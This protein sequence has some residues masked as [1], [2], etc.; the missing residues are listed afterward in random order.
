MNETI[1][2]DDINS[3][4]IYAPNGTM[5][6][7][8]AKTFEDISQGRQVSEEVFGLESK[9][10]IKDENGMAISPD[11]IMVINPFSDVKDN[12][13]GMLMANDKLRKDYIAIHKS[14]GNTKQVN[15]ING[16]K[17]VIRS[18]YG[19]SNSNKSSEWK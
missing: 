16:Y 17:N 9:W 18:I 15:I 5:K 10:E 6:S 14:M 1:S 12:S 19:A 8:F 4:I 3:S 7:S 13:Q 2:F 11:S